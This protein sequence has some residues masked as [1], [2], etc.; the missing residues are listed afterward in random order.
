MG[1]LYPNFLFERVIDDISL[2]GVSRK[3]PDNILR[4][5]KGKAAQD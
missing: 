5:K 4:F 2:K 1:N 3:S